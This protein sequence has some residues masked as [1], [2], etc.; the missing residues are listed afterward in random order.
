MITTNKDVSVDEALAK[1]YEASES[2]T[3]VEYEPPLEM[4]Y[5][6]REKPPRN[7]ELRGVRGYR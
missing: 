7:D 1:H 5:I 2:T 6:P 3:T 4:P